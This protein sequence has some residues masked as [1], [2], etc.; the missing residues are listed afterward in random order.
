MGNKQPE[1]QVE[2]TPKG[3]LTLKLNLKLNKFRTN[4]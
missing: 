2:K 1:P 4:P 3:N